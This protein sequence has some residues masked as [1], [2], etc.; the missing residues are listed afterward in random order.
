MGK[1]ITGCGCA[2]CVATK[3]QADLGHGASHSY[4]A[5]APQFAP[6]DPYYTE[7]ITGDYKWGKQVVSY[8]FSATQGHF[9]EQGGSNYAAPNAAQQQAIR[10]V[11]AEYSKI[12]NLT[13]REVNSSDPDHVDMVFRQ[14][15]LPDNLAGW[16]YSPSDE[17]GSDITFD[18]RYNGTATGRNAEYYGL[19][20][21]QFGF[22]MMLHEVG[23]AMGLVHPFEGSVVLPEAEDSQ[24][25][26]VMSYNGSDQNA[27]A[28]G[29]VGGA[30]ATR[31]GPFAPQTLMIYDIAAIQAIYGANHDYNAGNNTYT[32]TGAPAVFTLWDGNGTDTLDAMGHNGSTLDLREGLAF[33]SHV[34]E[35]SFWNAFGANIE[36]ATGSHG[37][38]VITGNTL[39]NRIFGNMGSDLISGGNGN[40]ILSAGKDADVVSGGSGNDWIN[41]NNANDLVYGED[42]DD[43]MR[44]GKEDDTM[45]GGAGN[46]TLYGDLGND[47]LSGGDGAD[48]FCFGPGSGADAISDFQDGLDKIQLMDGLTADTVAQAISEVSGSAVLN[49]AGG[50]SVTLTGISASLIGADDFIFG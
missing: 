3:A 33:V 21:G 6:G 44:G 50:A 15:S 29:Y 10:E 41:G 35:T 17:L 40:D 20:P 1:S 31:S 30:V 36:N 4:A 5:K 13:F 42:G 38:D 28:G 48:V 12:T 26:T 45:L 27:P 47:I 11:L 49:L 32:F 43:L 16:A 2:A 14:A 34:G 24:N 25:A 18:S 9:G 23:H 22:R 8:T 19:E 37:A 39:A 7:A 46:D